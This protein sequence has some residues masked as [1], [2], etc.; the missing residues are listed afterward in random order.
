MSSTTARR[1]EMWCKA[2][3]KS[4]DV[5]MDA[6]SG[7]LPGFSLEDGSTDFSVQFSGKKIRGTV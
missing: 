7:E 6:S 3:G 1:T 4:K 2:L 5:S